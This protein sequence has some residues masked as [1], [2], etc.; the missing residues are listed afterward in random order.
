[1][2]TPAN[3]KAH[4]ATMLVAT[5][6]KTK[7]ND[8]CDNLVGQGP[9]FLLRQNRKWN[10]TIGNCESPEDHLHQSKNFHEALSIKRKKILT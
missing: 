1:M 10:V 5:R 7:R 9:I 4:H 2:N 8:H 3:H 6:R